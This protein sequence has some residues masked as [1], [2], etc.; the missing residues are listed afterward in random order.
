[1]V[2]NSLVEQSDDAE[3]LYDR[4]KRLHWIDRSSLSC[5]YPPRSV[6]L[7]NKTEEPHPSSLI[8][9]P[10]SAFKAIAASAIVSGIIPINHP[11]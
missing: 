11:L 6:N 8:R 3:V 7:E 5:E 2:W 9:T 10:S 4:K 1:M